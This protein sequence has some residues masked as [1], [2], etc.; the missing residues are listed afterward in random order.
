MMKYTNPK[1]RANIIF[2]YIMYP[3]VCLLIVEAL[4]AVSLMDHLTLKQIVLYALPDPPLLAFTVV[5]VLLLTLWY[6]GSRVSSIEYDEA[7]RTFVV[8]HYNWLFQHKRKVIHLDDLRFS[9]YHALAP[10]LFYK[11]TVIRLTDTRHRRTLFFTSGL[12]WK[13]KQVDEIAEKLKEIKGADA[14]L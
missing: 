2:R 10:F 6:G 9:D 7:S 4:V 5:T 13:R 8:W 11:V 3:I 12:G 1:S 14:Y